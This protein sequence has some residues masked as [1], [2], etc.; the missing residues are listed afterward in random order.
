MNIGGTSAIVSPRTLS[1]CNWTKG[2]MVPRRLYVRRHRANE[3]VTQDLYS[4]NRSSGG[5]LSSRATFFF[6]LTN[7]PSLLAYSTQAGVFHQ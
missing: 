3:H 4:T 6:G 5:L 1:L 2:M 7:L